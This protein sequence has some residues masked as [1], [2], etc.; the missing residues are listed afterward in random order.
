VCSRPDCQRQRRQEYHRRNL[1]TDAEYQQVCWD[2]VGYL[3][4][5]VRSSRSMAWLPEELRYLDPRR[6][7]IDVATRL[8]NVLAAHVNQIA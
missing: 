8:M 5:L 7:L 4:W 1:H 2:M 3:A 6:K